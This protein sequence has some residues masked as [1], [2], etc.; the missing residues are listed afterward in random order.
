[1]TRPSHHPSKPSGAF[2]VAA[3][4]AVSAC[5]ELDGVEAELLVPEDVAFH[6]DRSF[7]GEDDDRVALVPLDLMVYGSESGEPVA[8][9]ALQVEPGFGLIEVL[10]ADQVLPRDAE[11]CGACSWDAWRDRYVEFA[12][13]EAPEGLFTDDD[14]LA[15]AFLLVDAFPEGELG[16]EPVPVTVASGSGEAIF[17]LVPQ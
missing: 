13:S 7:N 1:M 5:A 17:H 16:F 12:D 15:R 9:V 2:A 6:W 3:L 14:G 8:G 10:H 11:D 4:L